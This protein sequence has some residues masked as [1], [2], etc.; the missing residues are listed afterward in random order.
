[1]TISISKIFSY[2][3]DTLL[4]KFNYKKYW[5]FSGHVFIED[6]RLL[7]G[8]IMATNGVIQVIDQVLL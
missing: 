6:A 4:S 2:A 7:D 1:M 5:S 3:T 8:D